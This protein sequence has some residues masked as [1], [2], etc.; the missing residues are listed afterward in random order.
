MTACTD[1]KCAECRQLWRRLSE[2]FMWC[3]RDLAI[4]EAALLA[5]HPSPR[6]VEPEEKK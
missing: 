4:H 5:A 2:A 3:H 1:P 6:P